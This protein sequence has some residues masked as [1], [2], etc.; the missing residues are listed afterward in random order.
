MPENG[1][2]LSAFSGGAR[3]AAADPLGFLHG[4]GK[5]LRSLRYGEN[6]FEA[7]I[8]CGRYTP[9]CSVRGVY[10]ASHFH[11]YYINAPFE[12]IRRYIEDLA[13]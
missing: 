1:F 4:A 6:G 5:L 3:V 11:N 8:P 7:D 9:R 2:E 12:E 10:F 13:L